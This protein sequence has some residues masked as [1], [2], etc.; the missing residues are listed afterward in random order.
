M[1]SI[2]HPNCAVIYKTIPDAGLEIIR[3]LNK[4]IGVGKQ[5]ECRVRHPLEFCKKIIFVK[6]IPV[7]KRYKFV[8]SKIKANLSE[9]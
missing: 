7:K 1:S 8:K 2:C 9:Q 6:E 4:K 5:K 3:L